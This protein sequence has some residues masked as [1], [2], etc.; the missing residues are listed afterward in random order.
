MKMTTREKLL[1]AAQAEMLAQGYAATTVDE[2]CDRAGVSK[3]S[4]YHVFSTKEELGLALVEAF[5]QRNREI[6]EAAPVAAGD[7]RA[8]ALALANHLVA[9]AGAM[10]GGGCLLGAFALEL[11]E[12]NPTVA[13]AVSDKFR[14]LAALLAAGLAPLADEPGGAVELAEEFIVAVEGSLILARAHGDWSYVERALTRFLRSAGADGSTVP[15][16]PNQA[17]GDVASLT[18]EGQRDP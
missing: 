12:T 8:R 5:F 14:A 2:L 15:S 11:A 18:P 9:S 3:G 16:A 10:W 4:F 7:A 17:E 1:A 6:V 13:A